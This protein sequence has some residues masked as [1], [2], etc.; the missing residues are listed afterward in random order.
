LQKWFPSRFA[1]KTAANGKHFSHCSERFSWGR[2]R[3]Q[4][5]GSPATL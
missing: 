3:S 1:K 4:F 5:C 2:Y